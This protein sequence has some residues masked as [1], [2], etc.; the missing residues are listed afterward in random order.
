MSF[1][2]DYLK[3]KEVRRVL[4]IGADRAG[5][6]RQ[7]KNIGVQEIVWVEANP[8]IY[9]EMLDRLFTLRELPVRNKPYL[10]LISDQDDTFTD[11]NLYYGPDAGY[12]VGNKG[13]SSIL[14]ADPNWWGSKGYKGTLKLPSLTI[15]TFLERNKLGFEFDLLNMDTQ[16]AELMIARGAHKL[17]QNVRYINS[18]VTYKNAQY[19][20]NPLF[21]E[22]ENHFKE[23]GFECVST[24]IVD[25]GDWGDALFERKN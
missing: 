19:Q 23:Y 9:S 5:E 15:D 24:D 8:E 13:M 11:F 14:K 4:H 12:L 21:E 1:S 3:G 25:G 10:Q 2:N 6:L 16:G 17:L 20:D 22:I 18:E 7:Y